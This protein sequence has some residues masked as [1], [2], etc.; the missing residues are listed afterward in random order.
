[1]CSEFPNDA[2]DPHLTLT[3]T[4]NGIE[5]GSA[6]SGTAE[7]NLAMLQQMMTAGGRFSMAIAQGKAAD[8]AALAAPE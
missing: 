3:I 2:A 8:L 7:E 6:E 4:P 5:V 1:M